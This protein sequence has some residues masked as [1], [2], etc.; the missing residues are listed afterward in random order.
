MGLVKVHNQIIKDVATKHNIEILPLYEQ[1][2]RVIGKH[3][4]SAAFATNPKKKRLR[5]IWSILLRYLCF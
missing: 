5:I 1:L 2:S 4:Q 3:S